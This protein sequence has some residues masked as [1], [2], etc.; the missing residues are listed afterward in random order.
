MRVGIL[1]FIYSNDPD[2]LIKA[3]SLS[4]RITHSHP[5]ADAA[6]VA[7]AYAVKLALDRV[8]PDDMFLPLLKVTE[9]IS[10]EFTEA[11]KGS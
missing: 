11:L 4:G 9:G 2:K 5:I 7:G 3:A 1:C 8:A 6:S 10:E